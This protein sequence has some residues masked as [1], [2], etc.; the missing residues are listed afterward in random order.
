MGK[1]SMHKNVALFKPSPLNFIFDKNGQTIGNQEGN[2]RFHRLISLY[3]IEKYQYAPT[4]I[5]RSLIRIKFL[6]EL[7]SLSAR[8]CTSRKTSLVS[9]DE[10]DEQ[11]PSLFSD[12][13]RQVEKPAQLYSHLDDDNRLRRIRKAFIALSR[14]SKMATK[15]KSVSAGRW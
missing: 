7:K 9:A 1:R 8:C 6:D 11:I 2:L 4:H 15:K 3:Y 10:E 13:H 5:H 14:R 12:V